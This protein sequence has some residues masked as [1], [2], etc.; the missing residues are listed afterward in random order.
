MMGGTFNPPHRGHLAIANTAIE[1]LK[2]D[3]LWWLVTPQNPLK[4][5]QRIPSSDERFKL[6][7]EM[8]SNPRIIVSDIENKIGSYCTYDSVV[9]FQHTFP[10]T[11][12]VWIA[13]YDNALNFHKWENWQELVEMVPFCFIARPPAVSLTEM[14]PLRLDSSICHIPIEKAAV[15]PL[16]GRVCFYILQ[17]HMISLS[18]TQIREN[19]IITNG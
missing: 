2:L 6:C 1:M 8:V 4:K 7:R 19:L 16:D 5:H 18:S 12:F 9:S 15:W 11:N 3:A 17:M 13:G 14:C 10:N